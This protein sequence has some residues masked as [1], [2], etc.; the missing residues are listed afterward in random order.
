MQRIGE[1]EVK[2]IKNISYVMGWMLWLNALG[3]VKR[4]LQ[5]ILDDEMH[6]KR[7]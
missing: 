3:T 6:Y 2:N 7:F 1:T 4:S 5:Y